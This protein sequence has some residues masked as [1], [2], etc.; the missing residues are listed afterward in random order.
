MQIM[1]LLRHGELVY[2]CFILLPVFFLLLHFY[3][4]M[5]SYF[6]CCCF[7]I[8]WQDGVTD[9]NFWFAH[10]SVMLNYA[11]HLV[12]LIMVYSTLQ[13]HRR[14]AVALCLLWISPPH[15]KC[16]CYEDVSHSWVC[17]TGQKTEFHTA[18][19]PHSAPHHSHHFSGW[20]HRN[21]TLTLLSVM[22]TVVNFKHFSCFMPC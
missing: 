16:D 10:V 11:T 17:Q 22:M 4:R 12:C 15:H 1:I 18:G 5:S 14:H 3:F 6:C 2:C 20:S 21:D 19:S 13:W 9:T 7:T 8:Y